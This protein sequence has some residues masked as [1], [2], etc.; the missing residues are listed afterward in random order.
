MET[1]YGAAGDRDEHKRPNRFLRCRGI[2]VFKRNFHHRADAVVY[3]RRNRNADRHKYEEEAENRIKAR[4]DFID[5]KQR[6]KEVV[7]EDYHRPYF[8][9]EPF[10]RQKREQA[11]R[12][13]HK[14]DADH[15]EQNDAEYAHDSHH[16]GTQIFSR[17]LRNTRAVVSYGQHTRKI[18]VHR[19]GKNR[20]A[21]DPEVDARPPQ[22]ARN[23]AENRPEAGDVQ[24]LHEERA[25]RR[26]RNVVDTVRICHGGRRP[27][28]IGL[29]HFFDKR[30]V[31]EIPCYKQTDT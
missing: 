24:K 26:N 27:I 19:S 3:H 12:P 10:R 31:H 6:R 21:D 9:V 2:Q 23:R 14:D 20:T 16:D 1:G 29:K 11:C 18:I 15:D 17:D 5:G 4:D 7:D 25:R 13:Y 22:R 8:Y 28:R 30:S